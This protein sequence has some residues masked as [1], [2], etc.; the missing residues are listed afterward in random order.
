M[1]KL[2]RIR[3]KKFNPLTDMDKSY[4]KGGTTHPSL[5]TIRTFVPNDDGSVTERMDDAYVC[6]APP[7]TR[8]A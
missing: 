5:V 7:P 8:Y 3:L 1:K 4:I 2:E 6:D